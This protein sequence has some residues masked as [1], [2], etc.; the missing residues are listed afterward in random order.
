MTKALEAVLREL[1]EGEV[2]LEKELHV[3]ADRHSVEHEVRHVAV[4]LARWSLQN[5]EALE[6][7]LARFGTSA[8][9]EPQAGATTGQQLRERTAEL[10][11]RRP[12]PGLLLMRDVRHLY[13]LASGNSVLWTV[14]GQ[15]AQAT[16][17]TEL[18]EVVTACHERTIRQT[19]WCNSMLKVLSPQLLAAV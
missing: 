7:I 5:R 16:K 6:P 8:E 2:E 11:G 13:L 18:L 12:E 15:G 1:H 10:L 3:V 14:L 17:D 4:D 9:T 19:V